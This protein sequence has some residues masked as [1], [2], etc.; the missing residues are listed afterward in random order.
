ME[1]ILASIR[2]II[3]DE[4]SKFS[5]NEPSRGPPSYRE[6]LLRNEGTRVEN[7]VEPERIESL[8][9]EPPANEMPPS[10]GGPGEASATGEALSPA[11]PHIP[12]PME[13]SASP[14]PDD[15]IEAMLAELHS[16]SHAPVPDVEESPED[17]LESPER[18]VPEETWAEAEFG[19]DEPAEVAT[20]TADAHPV[21]VPGR[22]TEPYGEEPE[23]AAERTRVRQLGRAVAQDGAQEGLISAAT[24]AAVDSAFNAL[25]QTVLVQNGRTLEDLVRELL[26]P[27]LKA[28]LDDNLPNMVERLV[29]AEI[30][31]VSRGR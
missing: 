10:P 4:P 26:R 17:I 3:A 20:Q 9:N 12:A 5:R 30:E 15:D 6:P 1:E 2:R 19:A 22:F 23:R 28:W 31:R 14:R 18:V 25:A 13:V 27:M 8:R 24:S 11:R 16:Q 7:R 29:R 21:T